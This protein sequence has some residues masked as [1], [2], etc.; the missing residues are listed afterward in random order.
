MLLDQMCSSQ[1]FLFS[2]EGLEVK[3]EG[4]AGMTHAL[5]VPSYPNTRASF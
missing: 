3:H 5:P 4:Q 2:S 1:S